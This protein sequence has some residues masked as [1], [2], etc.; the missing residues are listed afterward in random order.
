MSSCSSFLSPALLSPRYPG[1]LPTFKFKKFYPVGFLNRPLVKHNMSLWFHHLSINYKYCNHLSSH[2][3]VDFGVVRL[4]YVSEGR[5]D[6]PQ[7]AQFLWFPPCRKNIQ[8]LN[9]FHT[10]FFFSWP[11]DRYWYIHRYFRNRQIL[12]FQSPTCRKD[13]HHYHHDHKHIITCRKDSHRRHLQNPEKT[14]DYW[15][16]SKRNLVNISFLL[17]TRLYWQGEKVFIIRY[18]IH[19]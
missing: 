14:R 4:W 5:K 19:N 8:W 11:S 17:P 10:F 2:S 6:P 9:N 13:I 18:V 16:A 1:L 15:L 3:A 7:S 12:T